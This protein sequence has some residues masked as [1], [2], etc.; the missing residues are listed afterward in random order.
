MLFIVA[1]IHE[2]FDIWNQNEFKFIN[3]LPLLF[4][5]TLIV[6][7]TM[8][9]Y[10][11]QVARFMIVWILLMQVIV[12]VIKVISLILFCLSRVPRSKLLLLLLLLLTVTVA[13]TISIKV[14]GVR[15][16]TTFLAVSY[17]VQVIIIATMIINIEK[18]DG[19][20]NGHRYDRICEKKPEI[21]HRDSKNY[22]DCMAVNLA[23]VIH[24]IFIIQIAFEFLFYF[25]SV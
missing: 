6:T 9:I 23:H 12:C 18:Y 5:S 11:L 10:D 19:T 21:G 25:I 24:V 22:N 15:P 17:G 20:K 4:F 2:N 8:I 16:T 3:Q 7:I 14:T 1:R 13:V